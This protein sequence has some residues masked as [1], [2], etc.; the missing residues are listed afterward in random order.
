MITLHCN[1]CHP[2]SPTK[3]PW[4]GETCEV[5]GGMGSFE[6]EALP[7]GDHLVQKVGDYTLILTLNENNRVI[8]A[9]WEKKP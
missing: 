1:S 7:S 5:C 6:V 4:T 2:I 8:K 3:N 9:L